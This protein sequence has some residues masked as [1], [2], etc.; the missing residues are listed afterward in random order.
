M[1]RRNHQAQ[2]DLDLA[3]VSASAGH[4][5]W[6]CFACH[7][8]VEKALKALH[9]HSGQQV[10]GHGLGRSFRSSV[11]RKGFHDPTSNDGHY[12]RLEADGLSEWHPAFL[13]LA[14]TLEGCARRYAHYCRR[15]RP[16][17]KPAARSRWGRR[18]LQ[19]DGG[20]G[21]R[22]FAAH[23]V[24]VGQQVLPWAS[25]GGELPLPME[26]HRWAEAFRRANGARG[27]QWERI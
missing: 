3:R 7:Q 4:P 20:S 25:G 17:A 15:Y 16:R 5:E 12:E 22:G 10:W 6:A 18:L 27:N 21:G 11:V 19:R 13:A 2:A 1:E 14:T 8:A 24:A 26:W 23:R 9:L